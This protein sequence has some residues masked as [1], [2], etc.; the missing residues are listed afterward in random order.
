MISARELKVLKGLIKVGDLARE[1]FSALFIISMTVKA[2]R[3][4]HAVRV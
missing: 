2:G 4:M 1:V 3:Q